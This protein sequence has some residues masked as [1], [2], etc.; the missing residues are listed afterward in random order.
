[1]SS[2]SLRGRL[3]AESRHRPTEDHTDLRR[4]LK[5]ETLAEHIAK[6]VAAWPP[7]LPEQRDRL[8]LLLRGGEAHGDAA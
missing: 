3:A 6:T 7:L 4:E 8:A 1:M 5:A 2:R